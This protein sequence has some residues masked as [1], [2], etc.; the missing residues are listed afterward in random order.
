MGYNGPVVTPMFT[1]LGIGIAVVICTILAL[2]H[3]QFNHQT[4]ALV[5]S[6]TLAALFLELIYAALGLIRADSEGPEVAYWF[7]LISTITP[8]VYCQALLNAGR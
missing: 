4:I 1:A 5:R 6:L 7:I 8:F 3:I 2:S